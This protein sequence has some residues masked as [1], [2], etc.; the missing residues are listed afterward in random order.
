MRA[1]AI[2]AF[3][4]V[5]FAA[6][7]ARADDDAMNEAVAELAAAE[8]SLSLTAPCDS[9]CKALQSMVRAADRICE[10][11]RDGTATDQ[12]RCTDAK[13][14]VAEATARVRAACP[15]CNPSPPYAPSTTPTPRPPATKPTPE[16]P[17]AT[18][19]EGGGS[20]K[21]GKGG[22]ADSERT[23][24]ARATP[25]KEEA[26]ARLA[27]TAATRR[28]TIALDV[29]PFF[30]P[31]WIV[32]PRIERNTG[33]AVSIVLTGGYGSLPTFGP[34]GPGRTTAI[35]LGGEV[36]GYVVGRSDGFGVFIAGDVM[37]RNATLEYGADVS[38]RIFPLG[39]TVGATLGTKL[40][41]SSGFTIEARAG[42]AYLADDRR[43]S[44]GPRLLPNGSASIGWTF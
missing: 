42:A 21:A 2:T 18:G 17:T 23:V 39:L 5:V 15:D 41:T 6:T 3:V 8:K 30:S 33:T 12:K 31:P 44:R 20:T 9:M 38:A 10:L 35:A 22:G 34:N 36:R 1:L 11:A 27:G 4:S 37:H 24:E 29:I 43:V 19:S 25:M 14:R 16:P 7:G 40:V 26:S 28:T 32:Q 13:Q